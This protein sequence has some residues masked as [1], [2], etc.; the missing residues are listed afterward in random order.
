[1]IDSF[2][3]FGGALRQCTLVYRNS[4]YH[5]GDGNGVFARQQRLLQRRRS[6]RARSSPP[7]RSITT[8]T[9]ASTSATAC[10]RQPHHPDRRGVRATRSRTMATTASASRTTAAA[11]A[12]AWRSRSGCRRRHHQQRGERHLHPQPVQLRRVAVPGDPGRS[13]HHRGQ[14]QRRHPDPQRAVEQRHVQPA[15]RG[16]EQHDHATTTA[17]GSTS[18]RTR[19][20]PRS[21]R[22]ST[23]AGNT[24]SGNDRNGILISAPASIHAPER[25][26]LDRR[27]PDLEQRFARRLHPDAGPARQPRSTRRST[28]PGTTIDENNSDGIKVAA[29][30]SSSSTADG[31]FLTRT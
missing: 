3:E 16:A 7:T 17:T 25:H 24:I 26:D 23:I 29:Y 31:S 2:A 14:W 19:G 15:H 5:N 10:P 9:T 20:R 28:S 1:M 22:A 12:P 4:I 11:S 8:T 21:R 30:L 18:R 27:Q 13:E 6:L